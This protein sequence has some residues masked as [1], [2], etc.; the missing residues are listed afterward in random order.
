MK[1][2][3]YIANC[4]SLS[5]LSLLSILSLSLSLFLSLFLSPLYLF[6]SLSLSRSL[7]FILSL[8]YTEQTNYSDLVTGSPVLVN[9]FYGTYTKGRPL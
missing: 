9:Y 3:M 5:P 8:Q 2:R 4:F 1:Q 7:S 6:L